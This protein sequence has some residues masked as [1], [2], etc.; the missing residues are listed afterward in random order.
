MEN[1]ESFE[2]QEVASM[3]QGLTQG[4]TQVQSRLEAAAMEVNRLRMS[5][6]KTP[7]RLQNVVLTE[8]AEPKLQKSNRCN[9]KGYVESWIPQMP[10]YLRNPLDQLSLHIAMSYLEGPAHEWRLSQERDGNLVNLWSQFANMVPDR[11]KVLNKEK[12]TRDRLH[13]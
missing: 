5:Q 2:N 3:I 8:S 11:F 9:G 10:N 6:H 12:I 13:K 7:T 4:L 1:Q